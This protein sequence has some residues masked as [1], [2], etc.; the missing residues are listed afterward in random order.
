MTRWEKFAK[1]KGIQKKKKSTKI[2]DESIGDYKPKFGYGSKQV[3][4]DWIM[5]VPRNI[6]PNTNMYEKANEE[7]K[8]RVGKNQKR[9]QRNVEERINTS[10]QNRLNKAL[11]KQQVE[12]ALRE[13]KSSTASLGKFDKKLNNE[14]QVKL[15][16]TQKRKFDDNTGNRG[17]EKENLNKIAD[18]VLQ[19]KPDKVLNVRKAVKQVSQKKFKKR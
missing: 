7:K 12:K 1:A 18:K 2:Y 9:Q 17:Q 13:T 15:K 14:E 3:Q 6:D 8:E 10:Q 4:D 16:R 19:G 11:K 5:E